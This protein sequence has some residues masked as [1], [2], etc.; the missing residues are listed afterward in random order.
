MLRSWRSLATAAV[1]AGA[2]LLA[3]PPPARAEFKVRISDGTTT[4]APVT[5]TDG[6]G[7]ITHTFTTFGGFQVV[8]TTAFSKPLIGNSYLADMDINVSAAPGTSLGGTI[9]VDVTDTDFSINPGPNNTALLQSSIVA[10]ISSGSVTF[11]SWVNYGTGGN[12]EF[13]G[14]D[15]TT[16]LVETT[17]LQGP[18]TG[19]GVVSNVSKEFTLTTPDAF[20]LTSRTVVTLAPGG[21]FASTDGNT[22]VLTPGPGGAVMALF[23]LPALGVLGWRRRQRARLA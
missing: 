12:N 21:T 9:Y 13:G 8:V 18:L 2:V 6:D 20:S 16:G 15:P 5:D 14:L 11:Q 3:L 23:A 19:I 4:L 17:D 1:L 22:R 10:N 7:V